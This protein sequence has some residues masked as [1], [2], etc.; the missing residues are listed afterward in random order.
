MLNSSLE[1]V[2]KDIRVQR[3]S[4][5]VEEPKSISEEV[6]EENHGFMVPDEEINIPVISD[7]KEPEII[8]PAEKLRVV[9]IIPIGDGVTEKEEEKNFMV[10]DFQDDDYVD[11]ESA[12]SKVEE[13]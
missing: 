5:G 10:N 6:V 11:F 2:G 3:P 8:T 13:N 4:Q 9:E 1:F 7:E 12:I